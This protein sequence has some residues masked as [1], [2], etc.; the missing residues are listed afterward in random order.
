MIKWLKKVANVLIIIWLVYFLYTHWSI[1]SEIRNAPTECVTIICIGILATWLVNSVQLKLLLSTQG[2]GISILENL[3]V[4]TMAILCNYLP[5]RIGTI[6]RFR[7]FKKNHQVEFSK[8]GGII[9]VRGILL[10]LMSILV[11]TFVFAIISNTPTSWSLFVLLLTCIISLVIIV[12]KTRFSSFKLRVKNNKIIHTLEIFLNAR[13]II[14][15]NPILTIV[16]ILLILVQFMLLVLRLKICFSVI[17]VDINILTLMAVAP[18]AI[19]LS[20]VA[21][22]PGNLGV[23]EWIISLIAASLGYDFEVAMVA[24][25]LDRAILTGL[26][27]FFGSIS[28][29]YVW[30]VMKSQK[31]CSP[32]MLSSKLKQSP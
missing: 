1:F 20:F 24:G 12:Y 2:V 19:V 14:F 32:P 8:F 28:Y 31:G 17:G 9:A 15:N 4:Q 3:V 26:T 30:N 10:L 27:F 7:Y 13:L 23:R 6:L 25:L 21:I 5:M 29:C 16:L 18:T 11:S 22:T